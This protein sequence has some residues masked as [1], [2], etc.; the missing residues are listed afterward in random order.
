MDEEKDKLPVLRNDGP[1]SPAGVPV[2]QV[3]TSVAQRWLTSAGIDLARFQADVD[4]DLMPRSR[5]T[6]ARVSGRVNLEA[7]M[8]GLPPP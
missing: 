8:R 6:G 4:R 2:V 1:E 7:L 3:K 5:V